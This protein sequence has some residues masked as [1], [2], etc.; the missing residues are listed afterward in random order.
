[1]TLHE[2]LEREQQQ[3]EQ[4]KHFVANPLPEFEPF[5]VKKSNKP[6]VVP[7][8]I[9]LNTDL[10]AQERQEFEEMLRR[11]EMEEEEAKENMLKM[12]MVIITVLP[13]QYGVLLNSCAFE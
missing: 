8:E 6:T 7:D 12:Q 1:M 10:R 13:S 3:E 2:Q 11:K 4:K 5:V 9:A